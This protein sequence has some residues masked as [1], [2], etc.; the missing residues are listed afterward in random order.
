MHP[1]APLDRLHPSLPAPIHELPEQ[2]KAQL[3]EVDA[4]SGGAKKES[5]RGG[6]VQESGQ[7]HSS[8]AMKREGQ[9]TG[10]GTEL[11]SHP[12]TTHLFI[13]KDSKLRN[14]SI[15]P[16][17]PCPPSGSW[18]HWRS[19]SPQQSVP[20]HRPV[21]ASSWPKQRGAAAEGSALRR[22][23]RAGGSGNGRRSRNWGRK[24]NE[25]G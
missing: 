15:L 17:A 5:F 24:E 9:R 22:R 13:E 1:G 21:P 14:K 7:L 25:R 23:R 4:R 10:K 11:P 12:I 8:L 6:R 3:W 19:N 16:S 20:Q 2:E 18:S